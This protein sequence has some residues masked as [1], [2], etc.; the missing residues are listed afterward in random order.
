MMILNFN[1]DSHKNIGVEVLS[2]LENWCKEF[3]DFALTFFIFLKYIFVLIL[4]T[5][6][7]LTLLKLKGIYLQ[8]RT[9]DLEK[10]EDRLKY[11]RLFMGWT[12]IFLGLGILFNYLIYFLIWVLEP[13]PDR[14]IFRFLNFHGKINPEHINRIKDINASKYPHEKSIY[15]CIA[16]ASFISTLDLILSVWYLI[17]NNRVISKPRAVIMNL[18]GSVMGVIMFGITTFL[19]FFL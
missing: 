8:V 12:Y 17:N 1:L 5:I 11:L 10:K 7:I 19:P 4:I 13:L 16:I 14:F 2:G 3:N 18:V 9:K 6:G 15:Y